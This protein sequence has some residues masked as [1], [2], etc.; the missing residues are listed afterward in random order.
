M[1]G[2][3][4][5]ARELFN[6]LRKAGYNPWCLDD[7]TE[8]RVSLSG[9]DVVAILN[10]HGWDVH[11]DSNED[12]YYDEKSNLYPEDVLEYVYETEKE[13]EESHH[14]TGR[15]LKE[16]EDE[17]GKQEE[18]QA[19]A[20]IEDG[21]KYKEFVNKLI[22]G[23][24]DPKMEK[25]IDYAFGGGSGDIKIKVQQSGYIPVNKLIPTQNFIGLEN[26]IGFP[27]TKPNE[28]EDTVTRM[29]SEES[30]SIEAG[31]P[32]WVFEGKF[33]IDGHHRWS[34]VYAFNPNSKIAAINFKS[35]EEILPKQALAA[36]QGVIA[37]TLGK[38]PIATSKIDG[39][40]ETACNVLEADEATMLTAAQKCYDSSPKKKEFSK[41]CE[42]ILSKDPER[43]IAGIKSGFNDDDSAGAKV[44]TYAVRNCLSLKKN[45]NSISGAPEREF[46]P[47]TGENPEEI[48]NTLAKGVDDVVKKIESW[49][50]YGRVIE[51]SYDDE[52]EEVDGIELAVDCIMN[53][54]SELNKVN[55]EIKEMFLAACRKGDM[56]TYY[57]LIEEDEDNHLQ[58][59]LDYMSGTTCPN[60]PESWQ[61]MESYEYD[62][63]QASYLVDDSKEPM[64]IF[65][66]ILR[67]GY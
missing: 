3:R 24:N 51:E 60:A 35:T 10:D 27:V 17:G 34:Q 50:R 11:K 41:L 58:N 53:A 28:A 38:V 57:N 9:V 44:L 33:I 49:K 47:Q 14:P 8:I 67:D 6:I 40:K 22:K 4:E 62:F 29:L 32:I 20:D 16:D 48:T 26:S 7:E 31:S 1:D 18:V 54:Q 15:M 64:D 42:N 45:N 43:K 55:P 37:S 61:D 36:V 5:K 59:A 21:I 13:L 19:P 23:V 39:K 56:E 66:A 12:D 30:P 63:T 65:K 46:M 52:E 2:Y 25:W